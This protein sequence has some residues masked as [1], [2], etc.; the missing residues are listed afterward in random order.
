[1]G[2]GWEVGKWRAYLLGWVG[3]YCADNLLS[4]ALDLGG[5]GSLLLRSGLLLGNTCGL[6]GLGGG[7]FRSSLSSCVCLGLGLLGRRFG[8]CGLLNLGENT[9]LGVA[10]SCASLSGHCDLFYY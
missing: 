9:W 8:G 10:G 1:V 7:S 4:F 2:G 6:A 5:H 3:G